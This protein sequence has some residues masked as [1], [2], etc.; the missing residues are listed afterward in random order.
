MQ[1]IR[2]TALELVD[3]ILILSDRITH[4]FLLFENIVKYFLV[5]EIQIKSDAKLD[6]SGK[7]AG[8]HVP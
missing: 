1:S 4:A 5:I 6:I 7:G 8:E 2:K 3:F